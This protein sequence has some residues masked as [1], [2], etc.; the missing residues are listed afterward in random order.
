MFRDF[1]DGHYDVPQLARKLAK[2]IEKNLN[3]AKDDGHSMVQKQLTRR[4][5]VE[6]VFQNIIYS[7]WLSMKQAN[8]LHVQ[9]SNDDNSLLTYLEAYQFD[10]N[11]PSLKDKVMK[12]CERHVG[13][14]VLT[15]VMHAADV[16]KKRSDLSNTESRLVIELHYSLDEH[17][18]AAWSAYEQSK[19]ED[20]L[21]DS[22]KILCK[23][24]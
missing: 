23:V 17:V 1:R 24:R 3:Q 8:W 4:D 18:K 22:L 9:F 2:L 11:F 14:A 19:N 5:K 20:D 10:K 12:L 21:L 13:P 16:F 15:D 6:T 7:D